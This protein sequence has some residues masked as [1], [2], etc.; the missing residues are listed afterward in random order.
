MIKLTMND[1]TYTFARFAQQGFWLF[2]NIIVHLSLAQA[3]SVKAR[4]MGIKEIHN[5]SAV[6]PKPE[7]VAAVSMG[8]AKKT[9]PTRVR[10][11]IRQNN[12]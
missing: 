3:L 10:L 12:V 9:S 5:F 7:P 1:K 11:S 4:Q 8:V 6:T 2:E